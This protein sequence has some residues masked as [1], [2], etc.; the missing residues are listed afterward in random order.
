MKTLLALAATL[1]LTLLII[2]G[3]VFGLNDDSI[4]VSPP[5]AVAEGFLRQMISK[6]YE[7]AVPYLSEDL[8]SHVDA[9]SLHT[10]GTRLS[11]R[12]GGEGEVRG[13]KGSIDGGHATAR[14]VITAKN[15]ATLNI[16]LSLVR[17]NGLWS[18]A[19]LDSL[20][21]IPNSIPNRR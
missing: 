1:A 4:F 20:A 3:I 21:S 18:I 12:I 14:A 2:A 15:G 17:H 10:L 13:E 19:S 5:E 8:A 9:D 11:A 7:R 6:R 16:P